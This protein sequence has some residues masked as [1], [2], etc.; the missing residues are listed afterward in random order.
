MQS[1][2]RVDSGPLNQTALSDRAQ[3]SAILGPPRP[4][5]TSTPETPLRCALH[6]LYTRL[7]SMP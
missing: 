6:P 7:Y 2:G 5:K 3:V 4:V 1:R